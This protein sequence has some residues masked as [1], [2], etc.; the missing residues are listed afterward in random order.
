MGASCGACAC[1]ADQL[2][3]YNIGIVSTFMHVDT[4]N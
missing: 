4:S 1:T 3:E 2:T